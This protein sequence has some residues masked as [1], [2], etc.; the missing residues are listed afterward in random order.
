MRRRRREPFHPSFID[1]RLAGPRFCPWAHRG[2]NKGWG[3]T[4]ATGF[5]VEEICAKVWDKHAE[6]CSVDESEMLSLWEPFLYN[7]QIKGRSPG[8]GRRCF[9]H[10]DGSQPSPSLPPTLDAPHCFPFIP[11]C[12]E[13][14]PRSLHYKELQA[15]MWN[16][17]YI[18]YVVFFFSQR[19]T[20]MSPYATSLLCVDSLP[21]KLQRAI[22][23]HSWEQRKRFLYFSDKHRINNRLAKKNP[24][25]RRNGANRVWDHWIF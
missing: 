11:P 8:E 1:R 17:N 3:R 24:P 2:V 25:E 16:L 6:C 12:S 7:R 4:R 5:A 19:F 21:K 20:A 23:E 10:A 18:I 9:L 22:N 14:A 13:P 15:G